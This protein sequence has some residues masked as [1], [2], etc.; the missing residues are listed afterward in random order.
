LAAVALLRVAVV[1]LRACLVFPPWLVVCPVSL[2]TTASRAVEVDLTL[3]ATVTDLKEAAVPRV[4][5][6][7]WFSSSLLLSETALSRSRSLVR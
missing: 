2:L 6:P 3:A 1:A 5:V 4:P 7:L